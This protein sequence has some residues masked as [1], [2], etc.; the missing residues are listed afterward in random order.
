MTTTASPPVVERPAPTTTQI[1]RSV[2]R[3]ESRAKVSG[4]AEY[5][6]NFQVPGMLH[7]KILRSTIPHGRILGI[8]SSAAQG[9]EGVYAVITGAEVLKVMPDPYYGPAFHDQPVLAIDK[10]RYVGEPVAA[11]LAANPQTAEAATDLIEVEYEELPSVFDEIEAAAPDAPVLHDV[12]RPAS[13]FVDLK[14]LDAR[15]GTNVGMEYRLRSGDVDQG[16]AEA[17]LVFED[18]FRTQQTMHTPLEPI[19]TAGE[20]SGTDSLV[21]HT[22]SQSPSF[23]RTEVARLLGWPENRVRVRTAYLGGGFGAKLYIKLEALVAACVLLTRRP[24]KISLTMEEQFYTITKHPTTTHIRTG[25]T[26]DGRIVARQV[27]TWWNGGAYA[28][29]G[30]R[31]TQKSGFTAGGPYDMPHVRLDSYAV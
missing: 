1:G 31:V 26:R 7:G 2:P 29:I 4:R 11:V 10:V 12:I 19:V 9:V 6:H 24:V 22:A 27:E 13:M 15:S 25:V 14:H 16:F 30:P 8:D 18:T 3:L 17:D 28:D 20:L 21:L 5:I 23:V